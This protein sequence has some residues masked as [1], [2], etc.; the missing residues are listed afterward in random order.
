MNWL[1]IAL[2]GGSALLVIGVIYFVTS[3]ISGWHTDS[4]HLEAAVA[5]KDVAEKALKDEKDCLVGTSCEIRIRNS[6]AD[7]KLKID[8]EK[9][10]A[11][12]ANKAAQAA[13]EEA[14]QAEADKNR[15]Q[16]EADKAKYAAIK[17]SH[18]T[19]ICEEQRKV[20]IV[21]ALQ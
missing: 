4:K 3:T 13:K 9:D 19:P 1:K 18:N 17:A 8:E 21:C 15:A 5:A 2:Y 11:D 6:A 7:A 12:K 10:K 14:A 16:V 20:K